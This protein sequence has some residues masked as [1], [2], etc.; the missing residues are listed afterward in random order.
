MGWQ[1]HRGQN[2]LYDLATMR[3]N[4][5]NCKRIL[6]DFSFLVTVLLKAYLNP[7]LT[8]DFAPSSLRP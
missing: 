6:L 4:F 5:T 7:N 8:H 3:P 1:T 2:G